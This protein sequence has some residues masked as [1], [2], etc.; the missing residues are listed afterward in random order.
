MNRSETPT[1]PRYQFEFVFPE[2]EIALQEIQYRNLIELI[3][4]F[5]LYHK[6]L[7]VTVTCNH[8]NMYKNRK[9]RPQMSVKESPREWW[10]YACI[11]KIRGYF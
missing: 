2:I 10:L 5:T 8:G 1:T 4:R 6:S 9:Y 11:N 3:E 7:K